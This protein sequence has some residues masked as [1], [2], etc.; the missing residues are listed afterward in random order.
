[1]KGNKENDKINII[2]HANLLATSLAF[3]PIRG[4]LETCLAKMFASASRQNSRAVEVFGDLHGR[5][6]LFFQILVKLRSLS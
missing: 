2:C 1:M 4:T 5:I 6:T 3:H